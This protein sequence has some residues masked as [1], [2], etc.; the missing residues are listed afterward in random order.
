MNESNHLHVTGACGRALG[1]LTLDLIRAGWSVSASDAVQYE[2]MKSLLRRE[3]LRLHRSFSARHVPSN[4]SLLLTGAGVR[5]GN[6]EVERARQLGI[7]LSNMAQFIGQHLT[8]GAH[9]LVVAG[10]KGKTTT[11]AM[12]AWILQCAGKHPDY[13]IGGQCPHF[14]LSARMRGAPWA[15]LEGDEYP[16]AENDSKPKFD[17]YQPHTLIV[18]NI[19]LDHPEVYRSLRH[20]KTAFHSLCRQLPPAGRLI[21][22]AGCIHARSL[23]QLSPADVETVGWQP[24]ADHRLTQLTTSSSGTRFAFG[25]QSFSLSLRGR[26]FALDA[27]LAA[28]AALSAGVSLQ[29]SAQ[30]LTAFK[31]VV[32]RMQ[33]LLDSEA[34]TLVFDESY[35]P[36][37]IAE[38]LRALRHSHP[39][40]RLVVALQPR[41]TGGRTG[42]QQREL[43]KAL[44]AAD[45]VVLIHPFDPTCFPDGPFSLSALATDL[46]QRGLAVL[47]VPKKAKLVEFFPPRLRAGDVVFLSLQPGSDFIIKPL[48]QNIRQ[49]LLQ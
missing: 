33:H 49:C 40:R 24:H 16:S 30:A 17:Y 20:L 5:E 6:P 2:P 42:F 28:R 35:H 22:N 47:P 29:V 1:P 34:L 44:A 12:L 3:G 48:L 21:V 26:M 41:F 7:P 38:N 37:A 9:R 32:G 14:Q 10:T 36:F 13:L 15:V 19:R 43:P 31:G 45:H 46:R 39:G 25:G 23:Q 8:T 4:T 27:A 11:T 18:T